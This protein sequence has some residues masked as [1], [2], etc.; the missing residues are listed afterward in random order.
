LL[1]DQQ[2]TSFIAKDKNDAA[3]TMYDA[4]AV[5]AVEEPAQ[6]YAIAEFKGINTAF[7]TASSHVVGRAG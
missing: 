2:I 7:K 5:Q 1:Y 4:W 6:D 3:K